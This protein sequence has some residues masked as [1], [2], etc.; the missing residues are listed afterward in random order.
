MALPKSGKITMSEIV[1][2]FEPTTNSA[3][4]A[5]S[6]YYRGGRNIKD[7]RN[8]FNI[9]KSG[10]IAFSDFYG[11]GLQRSYDWPIP[12]LCTDSFYSFGRF[13][14]DWQDIQDSPK[15]YVGRDDTSGSIAIP[16]YHP[17]ATVEIPSLEFEIG[18]ELGGDTE[19]ERVFQNLS[20]LGRALHNSG[21]S[22]KDQFG[23]GD[24]QIIVPKKFKRFRVVATSAGGSGSVQKTVLEGDDIKNMTTLGIVEEGYDG[25]STKVWTNKMSVEVDGGL[26]GK[27]HRRGNTHLNQSVTTTGGIPTAYTYKESDLPTDAVNRTSFSSLDGHVTFGDGNF[28]INTIY[29]PSST[30]NAG[31]FHN[32]YQPNGK[33][34]DSLFGTGGMPAVEYIWNNIDA[35][36]NLNRTGAISQVSNNSYGVGGAAGQHGI[37]QQTSR[38]SQAE[39]W[40]T[41]TRGGQAGI[42]AYLGDFECDGGDI[43][44]I[45]VGAG[46]KDSINQY[47]DFVPASVGQNYSGDDETHVSESGYGGHGSVQ[48][49]GSHGL[50]HSS[51]THPGWVLEDDNNEIMAYSYAGSASIKGVTTLQNSMTA[52]KSVELLGTTDPNTPRMYYLRFSA[53]LSKNGDYPMKTRLCH[54]GKKSVTVTALPKTIWTNPI[55]DL[56]GL[57]IQPDMGTDIEQVTGVRRMRGET[58]VEFIDNW[59]ISTCDITLAQDISGSTYTNTAKFTKDPLTDEGIGPESFKIGAL[60]QN[61]YTFTMS[62]REVYVLH[63]ANMSGSGRSLS[64]NNRLASYVRSKGQMQLDETSADAINS[65]ASADTKVTYDGMGGFYVDTAGRT[66]FSCG[67]RG[68]NSSTDILGTVAPHT[69]VPPAPVIIVYPPTTSSSSDDDGGQRYR[70]DPCNGN[71]IP[72]SN[73]QYSSFHDAAQSKNNIGDNGGSSSSSSGG[74]GCFLTTAIVARRGEEDDGTTLNKLR[75]YRDTFLLEHHPE[76]L[77]NY[78]IIAPKLVSIIPNDSVVWDWIGEQVDISIDHIDNG[79]FTNAYVTYKSMV[80]KLVKDWI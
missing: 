36:G 76:E 35:G 10:K 79:R 29:K 1:V 43:I 45:S 8:N 23:P 3:P 15:E 60:P 63:S 24:W 65:W 34:G 48:I 78:Y 64:A 20:V 44:N 7:F 55:A 73:G 39:D 50:L 2:N 26:G 6:E 58:D 71:I 32:D 75:N 37:R 51:L 9:P 47:Q 28:K 5:L 46:G 12:N 68:T 56:T 31:A 22:D 67:H 27:P 80:L 38:K 77:E 59:F 16:I 14:E 42:T 30:I 17:Q 52:P 72:D 53:R 66:C 25:G 4:H 54:I 18:S 57:Y 49:I 41:T 21:I 19:Y 70:L 40:V 13:V 33:G 69:Y 62:E 74:G 61:P 11:A